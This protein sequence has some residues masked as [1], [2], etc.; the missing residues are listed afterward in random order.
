M[1]DALVDAAPGADASL[2]L[3]QSALA[4][5]REQRDP[6]TGVIPSRRCRRSAAWRARWGGTATR[7]CCGRPSERRQST[8]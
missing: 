7:C 8:S 5:L 1:V 6:A 4:E 3:L 2:P